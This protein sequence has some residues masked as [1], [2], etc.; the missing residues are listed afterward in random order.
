M[1]SLAFI[2]DASAIDDGLAPQVLQLDGE[3]CV[4]GAGEGRQ[5]QPLTLFVFYATPASAERERAVRGIDDG[6]SCCTAAEH[7]AC[8]LRRARRELR[9]R[10]RDSR[11]AGTRNEREDV[12]AVWN[13]AVRE[14]LCDSVNGTRVANVHRELLSVLH[15]GG[16]RACV[17]VG[18]SSGVD[19]ERGAKG[20][21]P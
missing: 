7:D 12:A 18:D 11:R 15:D 21:L 9:S 17:A 2:H 19:E 16:H 6:R 20:P 14:R 1:A 13:S 4:R 5:T 3:G 8:Q 10:E